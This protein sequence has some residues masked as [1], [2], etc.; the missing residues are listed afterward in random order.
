M[1]TNGAF[2][3]S[4]LKTIKEALDRSQ[5]GDTIKLLPGT[6][7]ETDIEVTNTSIKI[8][9]VGGSDVTILDAERQVVDRV[10]LTCM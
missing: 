2:S 7:N 3:G 10:T 1:S 6:Y 4:A 9:G 8:S 5:S